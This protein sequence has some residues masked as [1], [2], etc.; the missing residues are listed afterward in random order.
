[1]GL[2]SE[3]KELKNEGNTRTR[4]KTEM[5][6]CKQGMRRVQSRDL[7]SRWGGSE[8][9]VWEGTVGE[10]GKEGERKGAEAPNSHFW[11]RH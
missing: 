4:N 3:M 5:K 10:K 6:N 1:M 9:R 2:E 8:G 11:L 7:C